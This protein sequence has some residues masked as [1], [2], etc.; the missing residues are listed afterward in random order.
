MNL[1]S[2]T[3]GKPGD[4]C[5]ER[6]A[7]VS[8]AVCSAVPEHGT[9]SRFISGQREVRLFTVSLSLQLAKLIGNI[10]MYFPSLSPA[11]VSTLH[12]HLPSAHL[13]G[14]ICKLQHATA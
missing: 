12:S 3:V 7:R 8:R 14:E 4:P 1:H 2:L 11:D 13:E 9:G 6:P 10:H 5:T